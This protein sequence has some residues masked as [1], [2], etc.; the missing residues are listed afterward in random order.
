MNIIIE[1][2]TGGKRQAFVPQGTPESICEYLGIDIGNVTRIYRD[3]NYCQPI[4]DNNT[5]RNRT[6]YGF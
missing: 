1:A 2:I 6:A 4:Y 3:G 5:T